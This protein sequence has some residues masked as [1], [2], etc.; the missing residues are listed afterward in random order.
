VLLTEETADICTIL[1]IEGRLDTATYGTLDAKLA[2]LIA[3]GSSN[4]LVDC[5]KLDY[6]SSS[7]LRVFLTVLK[8]MT[9]AN[10]KF[11]LCSLQDNILEIFE[12]SGFTGIFPIFAGRDEARSA[13]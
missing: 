4:I 8:K 9:A 11:V 1:S 10:G 7:G 6:V 5:A 12:I 13:F 2:E 3:S